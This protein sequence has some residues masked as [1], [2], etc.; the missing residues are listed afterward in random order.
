ML[1][2]VE[3]ELR[4]EREREESALDR[5]ARE[6]AQR[7]LAEA[8]EA[9]VGAYVERFRSD[10]DERGRALVVRNARAPSRQVTVGAGALS[11]EAPCCSRRHRGLSRTQLR[12][13]EN[14]STF[15]TA[16][17][18]EVDDSHRRTDDADHERSYS[19][20]LRSPT[21]RAGLRLG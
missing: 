7:M 20:V 10:R 11:V 5:L 4:Q 8:L 17:Q 3:N 6:G 15:W 1:K 9:E 16:A 12:H 21:A 13:A 19:T 14:D 2:V 18:I